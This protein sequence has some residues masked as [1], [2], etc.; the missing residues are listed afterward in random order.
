MGSLIEP[1]ESDAGWFVVV[2]GLT[3]V[4][5]EGGE[6]KGGERDIDDEEGVG[7]CKKR[8]VS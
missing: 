3:T 4:G 2:S 8:Y 1:E 6:I 7:D 5:G